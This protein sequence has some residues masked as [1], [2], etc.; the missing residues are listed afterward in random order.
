MILSE[1]I[2]AARALLGWD[3]ASLAHHAD[4]GLATVKRLESRPGVVGGTME[5]VMRIKSALEA[6][7]VEFI[8]L[9]EDAPGVRLRN[10]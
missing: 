9:P 4:V 3:Q 8:G 2:K 10:K 1:Q 7:G 6:A 5:T